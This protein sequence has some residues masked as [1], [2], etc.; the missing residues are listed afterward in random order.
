[1]IKHIAFALI[2][3][4]APGT[5]MAHKEHLYLWYDRPAANWNEALP[6][7]GGHLGAMVYGRVE[8]ETIALNDNTL[9]S[10]EPSTAWKNV[11]ITDTYDRVV[12]SLR[13]GR[14]RAATR[15]VERNWLGRLHQNYQPLCD[16]VITN[17]TKG[18]VEH[19]RRSL[20]IE[21]S[22]MHVSYVQCGVWHRREIFA[23][24]PDDVI[25][26]RWTADK[27]DIDITVALKTVHPTATFA[28]HDGIISMSGQ[29]PGYAERRTAGQ[30]ERRGLKKRH[31]E[32]YNADG[33]RRYNK[34][35]LYGSEIDGRGMYFES[36]LKV[37]ADGAEIIHE[38]NGLR[39]K[40]AREVVIVF[41]SETSFNGYDKSPSRQGR[42]AKAAVEAVMNRALAKTYKNLRRRHMA[43]YRAL[44]DRVS[45]DLGSA[46]AAADTMPTDRRI[47]NFARKQDN[48]LITLL[49][50]YGRYLMISGSRRGGQPLNLQGV[51]NRSVIPPWNGA[52]TMNINTEMNYWPAEVTGLAECHEPLFKLIKELS[53]TGR[54]AARIMYG[55]NGWVSHHNTSI[56]R[57]AFPNDGT[58]HSAFWPM[59]G[60]WLCS[61]LWEHYLFSGDEVFL[62]DEA[63][64]IMRGA[65]E[66][67]T[68]WLVD[69][70]HG[71][72]V[73]PVSTSPENEFLTPDG[74]RASVSMG[75]TM[76]MAIIRELFANTIE[77]ARVLG[78]EDKHSL[79]LKQQLDSLAPY[80]INSAGR[81]Q[82][83][84]EDFAETDVN[85][86]HMSHLYGL[87]PGSQINLR[88]PGLMD[89]ATR[90]MLRRGDE[91]TGWSMGW[92]INLWARL[93]DGDHANLIIR[94]LFTPVG[95]GNTKNR[96]GGLYLN[97]FDAHPPFQID[98]NF[99]YT[100][101]VAEMLLQSHAGFISLL[102]ALPSSWADGSVK[103]LRARGGFII[104]IEWCDGRPI[105]ARITSTRGGNCRLLLPRGMRVKGATATPASGRN[106]N[107]LSSYTNLPGC[108]AALTDIAVSSGKQFVDLTTKPGH[109]YVVY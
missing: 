79:R 31:P 83:W 62:R 78:V 18:R 43:D 23:S 26:M 90:S 8:G 49:F 7:A 71:R 5:I 14:Y 32:F 53:V 66:F 77:A 28:I 56:W 96:G 20:D 76:D 37:L 107:P 91:A 105:K 35:V 73:T 15:F 44:F 87:Y 63:Y 93:H 6:L 97:M 59:S 92:K 104:D 29:A 52:Y 39:V 9:Y 1:M 74:Q 102:P 47:E 3:M 36:R 48:A 41:A 94:N 98:G 16:I 12:D 19:Y 85:H 68:D 86:R 108:S 60:A 42:D 11:S 13:A 50:Q 33:T 17:H 82:E 69:D 45:L 80:R 46:G 95:F 67:F 70:G 84:Q 99:G 88:T 61:H 72:L 40:N 101:G 10:G 65:T 25:V 51:W 27:R 75:A 55:R 100:A 103:G 109:T 54:E 38:D 2:L 34:Q 89:A 64:P 58:A 24:H 81:I 30:I 22:L 57:E 4:L 21:R 106:P